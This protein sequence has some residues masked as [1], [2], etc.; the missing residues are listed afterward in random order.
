MYLTNE[1]QLSASSI[2][3]ATSALRFLYK[4]TLKKNW[5]LE[6]M[7][8]APKK[9]QTLPV[10]L[11]PKEVEY[12]LKCVPWCKVRVLLTVCYAAGLRVSEAAAL[13]VSDIDSQRMTIRVAQG[14]GQNDRYVMLSERL[15]AIL[16]DWYCAARPKL[17]LFPGATPGSHICRISSVEDHS[18]S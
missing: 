2:S 18:I 8:P 12:F 15:L 1:K 11:S 17:W 4:V 7:I 5:G 9:P 13:K 3:L 14:K 16:R 10:I 6:Q